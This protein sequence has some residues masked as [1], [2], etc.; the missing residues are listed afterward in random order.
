MSFNEEDLLGQRAQKERAG[1]PAATSIT[2]TFDQPVASAADFLSA[3]DDSREQRAVPVYLKTLGKTVLLCRPELD[4]YLMAG[5]LPATFTSM[6]MDAAKKGA[7]TKDEAEK[8]VEKMDD[9]EF[10]QTIF[11][12]R[13]L[14]CEAFV[15]PKVVIVVNDPATEIPIKRLPRDTLMEVFYWIMAGS[16][17][18]PVKKEGGEET[19]IDALTKSGQ[20]SSVRSDSSNV[21]DIPVSGESGEVAANS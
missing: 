18:V 21:Q 16:P 17:D 5:Q 13:D 10:E 2:E 14:V 8:T 15:T 3:I 12:M 11:F 7:V 20:E 1:Q 6:V 19:S 9:K 4:M